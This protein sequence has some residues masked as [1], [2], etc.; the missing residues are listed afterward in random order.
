[1]AIL[2]INDDCLSLIVSY[3]KFRDF[4]RLT[5]VS[6]SLNRKLNSNV[7]QKVIRNKF[8]ERQE[9]I[10]QIL[11]H[12]DYHIEVLLSEYDETKTV[13]QDIYYYFFLISNHR[14]NI[15]KMFIKPLYFSLTPVMSFAA[16]FEKKYGIFVPE[17]MYYDINRSNRNLLGK[18]IRGSIDSIVSNVK[19]ILYKSYDYCCDPRDKDI[20]R[21]RY[22]HDSCW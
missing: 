1:M 7:C 13:L 18:K 6:H 5:R 20:A 15:E 21:E 16:F 17:F 12:A 11:Y 3:L 8:K 4:N 9:N 10:K 14:K 22:E 2:I 19:N